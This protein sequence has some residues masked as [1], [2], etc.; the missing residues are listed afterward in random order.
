MESMLRSENRN[1]FNNISK[2]PNPFTLTLDKVNTI[3]ETDLSFQESIWM[4][5][6]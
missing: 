1:V 6:Q 2:A 3:A 5:S 4:E